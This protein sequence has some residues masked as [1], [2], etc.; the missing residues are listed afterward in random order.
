MLAAKKKTA[1]F[2]P[3]FF[4]QDIGWPSFLHSG[5]LEGVSGI[6]ENLQWGIWNQS[7]VIK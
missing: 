5:H 6:R 2:L 1:A 7:D 3:Q 4:P